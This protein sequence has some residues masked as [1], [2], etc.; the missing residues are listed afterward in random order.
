M[1]SMLA[2]AGAAC[3]GSTSTGDHERE[4]A[5]TASVIG[6]PQAAN[7]ALSSGHSSAQYVGTAPD[8]AR[9]GFDVSVKAPA[10]LDVSVSIPTWYGADFPSILTSSRQPGVCKLTG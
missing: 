3:T 4:H 1:C 2:I 9:Y 10:S 6:R 8:P 7:L 5:G